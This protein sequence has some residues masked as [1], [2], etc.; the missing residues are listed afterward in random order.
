M[1]DQ[2]FF[3]SDVDEFYRKQSDGDMQ[4]DN[5]VAA[6]YNSLRNIIL[7]IQIY[8]KIVFSMRTQNFLILN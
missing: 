6:I 1:V 3:W 4:R 5:D 8:M 2:T 7:T